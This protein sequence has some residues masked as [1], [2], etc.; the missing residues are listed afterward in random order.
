[1]KYALVV[2]VALV[3]LSGCTST[4]TIP[5]PVK[6]HPEM[7]IPLPTTAPTP[8]PTIAAKATCDS[9]LWSHVYHPYRLKV[10]EKCKTVTGTIK[11]FVHEAD[12]DFHV[13]L[14]VDDKS[15]V[16]QA[17][18]DGQHGYLLLEPICQNAPTQEDADEPCQDYT[19]PYFNVSQFVGKHVAVTGSYVSDIDHDGWLEIHPVTSIEVD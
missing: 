16:N 1:M 10:I 8:I 11:N 4:Q 14:D 17:N 2:L 7:K 5:V 6:V 12:G 15:L 18:I 13:R 3:L 19:G 9:S